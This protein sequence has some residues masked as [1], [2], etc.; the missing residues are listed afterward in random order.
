MSE[1]TTSER[2]TVTDAMVERACRAFDPD[3]D[4]RINESD[5]RAA[6]KAALVSEPTTVKN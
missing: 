6:L 4:W 3:C 2:P 1:P 5:I